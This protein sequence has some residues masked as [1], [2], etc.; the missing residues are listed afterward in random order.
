[1]PLPAVSTTKPEV[2]YAPMDL[3]GIS[4]KWM[5]MIVIMIPVL[6]RVFVWME[7][8]HSRV[9]AERGMRRGSSV[10]LVGHTLYYTIFFSIILF[11]LVLYYFCIDEQYGGLQYVM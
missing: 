4:A 8:M 10:K 1:M 6:T 3:A 7:R 11:F 9:N 5:W 2:V